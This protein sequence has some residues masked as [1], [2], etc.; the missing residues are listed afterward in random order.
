MV[1]C[2]K[3]AEPIEMFELWAC[4]GPRNH[5]LDGG[6]DL[7]IRPAILRG[8]R[9]GPLLI[10]ATLCREVCKMTSPNAVWVADSGALK[11]TC[12]VRY[13]LA[14]PDEYH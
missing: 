1:S 7:S 5:V 11:E 8:K 6:L 14:Q 2:A 12:Y 3:M 13:A 10:I 4:M 9:S